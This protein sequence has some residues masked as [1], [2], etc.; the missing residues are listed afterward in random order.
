M[1]MNPTAQYFLNLLIA[2]DQVGTTVVGG[3]PDETMS[4]YAYRMR[5][6]GKPW[7]FLATWIDAGARVIFGQCDHCYKAYLWDRARAADAWNTTL[8]TRAS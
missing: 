4:S 5:A 7:G 3:R 6:L 2:L 8:D 1:A